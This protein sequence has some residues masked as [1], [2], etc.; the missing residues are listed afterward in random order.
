WV[1]EA[2]DALDE[3]LDRPGGVALFVRPWPLQWL[4]TAADDADPAVLDRFDAAYAIVDPPTEDGQTYGPSHI[5]TPE[6]TLDVPRTAHPPVESERVVTVRG[7]ERAL[8]ATAIVPDLGV[9][10]DAVVDAISATDDH[11][12]EAPGPG[13]TALAVLLVRSESVDHERLA[14]WL[15]EVALAPGAAERAERALGLPPETLRGLA[16]AIE[17]TG[18]IAVDPRVDPD[19]ADA[20]DAILADHDFTAV[21][22]AFERL[23]ET[24]TATTADAVGPR[25]GRRVDRSAVA[26]L[27]VAAALA[28]DADE[29]AAIVEAATTALVGDDG[30]STAAIRS[31]VARLV[32]RL[33][34]DPD[35]CAAIAGRALGRALVGVD[36]DRRPSIARAA[37]AGTIEVLAPPAWPALV[38]AV[39]SSPGDAGVDTALIETLV[40][41]LI[42]ATDPVRAPPEAGV[43]AVTD[44]VVGAAIR[45]SEDDPTLSEPV[46]RDP[47]AA[48]GATAAAPT[49]A[50]A[51]LEAVDRA[52]VRERFDHDRT[53]DP[54][55][56]ADRVLARALVAIGDVID[57]EA[58]ATPDQFARQ[59]DFGHAPATRRLYRAGL[60]AIRDGDVEAGRL[61]LQTAWEKRDVLVPGTE[62]HDY[63]LA[64]GAVYAGRLAIVDHPGWPAEGVLVE[65]AEE[66]GEIPVQPRAVVDAVDDDRPRPD[67]EAVESQAEDA[68]EGS[69][70]A[71]EAD[72]I[73][74]MVDQLVEPPGPG[75][76]FEMGCRAVIADEAESAVNGFGSAWDARSD[77][78]TDDDLWA[79]IAGGVAM[80][81]HS[82]IDVIPPAMIYQPGVARQLDTNRDIVPD[83]VLDVFEG[84][85]SEETELPDPETLAEPVDPEAEPNRIDLARVAF[86]RIAGRLKYGESEAGLD[87][88]PG[89]PEASTD[90]ES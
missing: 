2:D 50:G 80:L 63:A 67:R 53:V 66:A 87:A 71:L 23:T 8:D 75:E 14:D 33:T 41:R 36:S 15:D 55:P 59:L 44:A 25:S 77:A 20:I 73:A 72:V 6:R 64:A 54:H 5:S 86:A 79:A 65:L 84:I 40:D 60:Q 57:D 21:G 74:S 30:D 12:I 58:V 83:F 49:L 51:L 29:P 48:L 46:S 34:G 10:V 69:L 43:E 27:D 78:E 37:I 42:A 39:Q 19:F 81:A 11:A 85:V 45:A 70:D 56:L 38:A 26:T 28:D 4:L 89:A 3:L 1:R 9:P 31:G 17:A 62:G 68:A 7:V 88:Y 13:P 82:R 24:A 35:D 16:A 32:A 90:L 52:F 76:Y 22:R 61:A 18:E 47:I